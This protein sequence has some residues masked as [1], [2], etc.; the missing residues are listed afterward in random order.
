MSW[1]FNRLLLAVYEWS[2]AG[3]ISNKITEPGHIWGVVALVCFDM[4]AIFSVQLVRSKFYNF[5]FATHAV[6]LI[7]VLFAVSD[8][9]AFVVATCPF[10]LCRVRSN[11]NRAIIAARLPLYSMYP[12]SHRGLR[13]LWC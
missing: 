4:L 2:L 11:S 12:L 10:C 9:L 1:V 7:V 13:F 3:T 8:I 5:F 6:G